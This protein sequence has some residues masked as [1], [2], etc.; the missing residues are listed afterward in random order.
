[1]GV[2]VTKADGSRQLFDREKIVRTCLRNGAS[3]NIAEE[4]AGKIEAKLY[5]GIE[6]KKILDMI[7]RLLRRHEPV[8]RHLVDLRRGLSSMGPKTFERFVQ[9]LLGEHGYDVT[10]NQILRGRCVEHEVD[11]IAKKDGATYFVEVK[12]HSNNHAQTGLDDSRIARAVLE[13]VIEG[14]EL[15]LNNLKIDRAMIVTNTKFSEHAKRYGECRNILQIGWSSPPY[16]GLQDLI[17]EKGL[18]PIACFRRLGRKE[19]E[20][21]A[22]AGIVLMKQLA[23]EDLKELQERTGIPRESLDL[24]VEKARTCSFSGSHPRP[25]GDG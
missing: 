10:P 21:L 13:D 11:A 18:H 3:R 24:L 16:R 25:T 7:F 19:T 5:N 2:F 9:V 22:M 14:F 1:M 17:E 15:G 4:I 23:D 12:H 8:V 20:K 6:T